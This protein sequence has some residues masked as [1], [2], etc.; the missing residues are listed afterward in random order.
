MAFNTST[1]YSKQTMPISEA[2]LIVVPVETV[3]TKC[4]ELNQSFVQGVK[5]IVQKE[6]IQGI[7]KGAT[8]TAL[9]QG[10]NQ[11]LRFMWF[12]EYKRL[13]LARKNQHSVHSNLNANVNVNSNVNANSN[14]VSIL[15]QQPIMTLSSIE[16]FVGGMTAGC[17][18]TLGNNPLD[19]IKTR[20]QGTGAKQYANTLDCFLQIV[21][22]EGWTSLYSGLIPRLG[23]V[24][25]GQ[26]IIFFSFETIQD[27]L[28][29]MSVF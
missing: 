17:F 28:K 1:V 23:R 16:K 8:A 6:G 25:P 26:G 2:L 5:Y 4:I 3:K 19:V 12:H 22:K 15:Q 14:S 11:G 27:L 29:T 9:K 20:M 7:Y 21:R 10:S 13:V 24:V 18:S